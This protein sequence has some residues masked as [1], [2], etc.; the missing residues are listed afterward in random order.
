[1]SNQT[2]A[3]SE[4]ALT[5]GD[6]TF[7]ARMAGRED[8]PLVLC[9]HGFPQTSFAYRHQL[10]ALAGAG[11]RAVAPDQRGYSP[12]ARFDSVADYTVDHLVGDIVDLADALDAQTFHLVGHDWGGAVSWLVAAAHPDRL[13]SL[14]ILSRPHPF[15]F[16][17]AM[18]ETETQ[19]HR[20][21]H[22]KAFQ[23]PNTEDLLLENGARRLRE[24]LADQRVPPDAIDAYLNVLGEKSALTAALNWYRA[25]H[26]DLGH[27]SERF[28]DGLAH[29]SV[30][31]LYV[32]G[33]ED[34]TVSPE[35]AKWTASYVNAPYSFVTLPGVGHFSTDQAPQ[36]VSQHLIRH[37]SD[38]H[39]TN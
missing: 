26:G 21:R 33:D 38:H 12:G 31:T 20:S 37:I 34:A 8:A 13:V 22:H 6:L 10:P 29:I 14:S 19:A 32:W 39:G 17:R 18:R 30:P 35:A 36:D 27:A 15:A 7:S 1:M 23:D 11:F 28:R 24:A 9:L 3:V 4:T 25:A 16:A 5:V 2:E